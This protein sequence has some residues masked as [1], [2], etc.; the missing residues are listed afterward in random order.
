MNLKVRQKN[1]EREIDI[2][3]STTTHNGNLGHM[4]KVESTMFDTLPH[5]AEQNKK[6]KSKTVNQVVVFGTKFIQINN[7]IT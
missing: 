4:A 6:V 2:I 7:L 3:A 1:S 5:E